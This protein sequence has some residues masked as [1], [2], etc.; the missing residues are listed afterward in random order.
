MHSWPNLAMIFLSLLTTTAGLLHV[1]G[2]MALSGNG[3]T[4]LLCQEK[5]SIRGRQIGQVVNV[6]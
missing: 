3:F 2:A 4:M 5:G 6:W 1:A